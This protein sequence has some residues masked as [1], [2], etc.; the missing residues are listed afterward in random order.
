MTEYPMDSPP[1]VNKLPDEAKV[2][3]VIQQEPPPY[4][5]LNLNNINLIPTQHEP[6]QKQSENR[7]CLT[8]TNVNL[9]NIDNY[10]CWSIFNIL[11][12]WCVIGCVACYFTGQTDKFIKRG[13]R[14]AALN[15]SRYARNF[16]RIATIFGIIALIIYII[17]IIYFATT[18]H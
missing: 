17:R 7:A 11:C 14:Q 8:T 12:C 16:N 10:K 9:D 13:D 5:T 18:D 1:V 6:S 4:E 15:A 2:E 3:V